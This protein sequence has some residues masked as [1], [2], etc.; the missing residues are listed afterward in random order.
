MTDI[1]AE[2]TVEEAFDI[3]VRQVAEHVKKKFDMELEEEIVKEILRHPSTR[4]S[5]VKVISSFRMVVADSPE[6]YL[7]SLIETNSRNLVWESVRKGQV[8]CS[9]ILV[10]R[11]DEGPGHLMEK[12]SISF[13]SRPLG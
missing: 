1:L 12:I 2:Q 11:E 9:P 7:A 6:E 4:W 3:H 5:H 10:E 8:P 13:R